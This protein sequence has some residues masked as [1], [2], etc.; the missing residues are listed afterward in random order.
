M[1]AISSDA[2]SASCNISFL[3]SSDEGISEDTFATSTTHIDEITA[4]E[5]ELLLLLL[6]GLDEEQL[7]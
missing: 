1:I 7:S 3:A 5:L 4:V 6:L 2:V